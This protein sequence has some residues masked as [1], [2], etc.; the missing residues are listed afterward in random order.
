MSSSSEG[1]SGWERLALV[2]EAEIRGSEEET[3]D[4]FYVFLLNN[5]LNGGKELDTVTLTKLINNIQTIIR[6]KNAEFQ[7]QLTEY[8]RDHTSHQKEGREREQLEQIIMEQ[9]NKISELEGTINSL[10]AKVGGVGGG[11]MSLLGKVVDDLQSELEKTRTN[12]AT[13]KIEIQ[14]LNSELSVSA[15]QV[16]RLQLELASKD[17]ELTQYRIE[18]EKRK[19]GKKSLIEE[20]LRERLRLQG[21]EMAEQ[22]DKMELL[23]REKQALEGSVSTSD[24]EMKQLIEERESMLQKLQKHQEALAEA[25]RVNFDLERSLESLRSQLNQCQDQLADQVDANQ[26]LCDKMKEDSERA[27]SKLSSRSKL[28]SEA[29]SKISSLEDQLQQITINTQKG[30]ALRLNKELA[31]KETEVQELQDELYQASVDIDSLSAQ[32]KDAI[33]RSDPV[34]VSPLLHKEIQDMKNQLKEMEALLKREQERRQQSEKDKEDVDSELVELRHKLDQYESGVL[35]LK[36]A[37]NEIKLKKEELAH[38]DT[39]VSGLVQEVNRLQSETDTLDE[40]NEALRDKLGLEPGTEPE[41]TQVRERR[42]AE[43]NKLKRDNVT[44]TNEVQRLEEEKLTLR[45]KIIDQATSGS[46]KSLPVSVNSS[47]G[48]ITV[49]DLRNQLSKL[50]TELATERQRREAYQKEITRLNRD[51]SLPPPGDKTRAKTS[52][53]GARRTSQTSQTSPRIKIDRVREREEIDSTGGLV[54]TNDNGPSTAGLAGHESTDGDV[55][56]NMQEGEEL[57][58]IIN[59]L[60]EREQSLRATEQEMNQLK[61][62]YDIITHQQGLLYSEYSVAKRQWREERDQLMREKQELINK[63]GDTTHSTG[64]VDLLHSTISQLRS[65]LQSLQVQNNNVNG[66]LR[67]TETLLLDKEREISQLNVQIS[68]LERRMEAERRAREQS[69]TRSIEFTTEAIEQ[70]QA[71]LVQKEHQVDKYQKLL[72]DTRQEYHV[73]VESYKEEILLLEKKLRTKT[74]ALSRLQE[75]ASLS[76][77]PLVTLS[78]PPPPPLPLSSIHRYSPELAQEVQ[79][80]NRRLSEELEREKRERSDDRKQFLKKE[81]ELK[82]EL[83]QLRNKHRLEI[84]EL[85]NSLSSKSSQI[86]ELEEELEIMNGELSAALESSKKVPSRSL[87]ELVERLRSQLAEKERE[88]LILT[89]SLKQVRADLVDTVQK[90]LQSQ[91]RQDEAEVSV[92]RLVMERVRGAEEKHEEKM[93][94]MKSKT[95]QLETELD[96]V[97]KKLKES[98]SEFDRLQSDYMMKDNDVKEREEDISKLDEE[99]QQLKKSLNESKRLEYNMSRELAQL[100]E[101]N[102]SS[103]VECDRLHKRC[104]VLQNKVDKQ[105]QLLGEQEEQLH[106]LRM[107]SEKSSPKP[108]TISQLD[109]KHTSIEVARWEES[110]KWQRKIE[111]MKLK[112]SEKNK[113]T[114]TL[115]KHITTL[116][117]SLIRYEREKEVLAQR[118]RA[119]E[120]SATKPQD[121]VTMETGPA[122]PTL[123]RSEVETQLRTENIELENKVASLQ[124]SLK[125]WEANYNYD[126]EKLKIEIKSLTNINEE[127][128]KTKENKCTNEGGGGVLSVESKLREELLQSKKRL[129]HLQLQHQQVTMETPRLKS[130]IKDLEQYIEVLK[131]ANSEREKL[132]FESKAGYFSAAEVE[133]TVSSMKRLIEKLQKE[134]ETLKTKEKKQQK[135]LLESENKRLKVELDKAHKSLAALGGKRAAASGDHSLAGLISENERLRNELRKEIEK[136]EK[137]YANISKLKS[138]KS[139]LEDDKIKFTE[140]HQETVRKRDELKREN[141][142]LKAELD[143][144]DPQF[145]EEIEDLKYN[146]TVAVQKNVELEEQLRH[147]SRQYGFPLPTGLMAE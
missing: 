50:Q 38:R 17:N 23:L 78:S 104:D 89:D 128:M 9:R 79:D 135:G 71:Q 22:L 29:N 59:E 76:P 21:R 39:E 60:K 105:K 25:G 90:T 81:E 74:A 117:E 7:E 54:Y 91:C 47:P 109:N 102:S 145:F 113:E 92:Q 111:T 5:K 144:F 77:P 14:R 11:G 67:R 52:Q 120:K 114:D 119:A 44:L 108:S 49:A 97:K 83:G 72:Q 95:L 53:T 112:L 80:T 140:P 51:T 63:Q 98:C 41:L 46:T 37:M 147:Y 130:R 30:S 56:A 45:K 20:E 1:V 123:T 73:S 6:L 18:W 134:N 15:A 143:S 116:K 64:D 4:L 28:L 19:A 27:K 36:E 124:L 118:L 8:E 125:E 69:S 86:S 139:K 66:S 31:E 110:K 141:D 13:E 142:K 137:L 55:T 126:V 34:K 68:S 48:H 3:V 133:K 16:Q 84:K 85:H 61:N 94:E 136:S 87:R 96:N 115:Q 82:K 62:K 65:E 106:S 138:D 122:P 75:D 2:S 70:L 146:V 132:E 33:N 40:I 35:G 58:M 131:G 127:L 107:S 121:L 88:L 103:L 32:L 10:T 43:L 101:R 12:V 93:R 42:F 129:A 99:I 26:R 24:K 100:K 57:L